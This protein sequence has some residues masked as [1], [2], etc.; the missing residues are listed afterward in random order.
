MAAHAFFEVHECVVEVLYIC[1]ENLSSRLERLQDVVEVKVFTVLC[2]GSA[3]F[4]NFGFVV[5]V[6]CCYNCVDM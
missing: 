6:Y 5:H 1:M 3:S 2:L 4:I